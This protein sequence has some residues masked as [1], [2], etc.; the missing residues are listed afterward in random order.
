MRIAS[1]GSIAT[2]ALLAACGGPQTSQAN[3]AQAN[4]SNESRTADT[5][6]ASAVRTS[7]GMVMLAV[8][9]VSGAQAASIMHARHEG[10][11]S[12]GKDFKALKRT[13]EADDPNMTAARSAAV[14]IYKN[15]TAASGWFP[16]GTGPEAGK[17]GAKPD[18]WLPANQ[19]D[20]AAKLAAFQQSAKKFYSLAL[21]GNADGMKGM[22]DDLAGTCKACHDKYRTEMHH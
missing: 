22:A 3:N 11:E 4:T 9:S 18:I 2:L 17:T 15:S 16:A 12:M 19:Q 8:P 21:A 1:F 6:N 7:N 13:L 10:M 14:D 5:A 20:F